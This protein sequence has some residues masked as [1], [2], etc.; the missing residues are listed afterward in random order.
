[1]IKS[2]SHKGLEDF[3]YD[4]TKRGIQPKHAAKLED[5]LDRLNQARE[6]RDMGYSGADLHLLLPKQE[7]RWA[8]KVSGNWRITFIF[9]EGHSYEVNYEDYH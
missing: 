5:I 6:I 3:F 1:M 2:F 9:K 8:V 7:N 4:S